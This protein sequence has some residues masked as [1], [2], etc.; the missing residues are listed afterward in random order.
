MAQTEIELTGS[1]SAGIRTKT[2]KILVSAFA[3]SPIRGSEFAVGWEWIR[4]IARNHSVWAITRESEREEIE[5]YLRAHPN[6]LTNVSFCFVP[7]HEPSYSG[8]LLHVAYRIEYVNW[9]KRCFAMARD[10]DVKVNFDIVH[11]VNGTGFREPGFLWKLKKPFVWGPILGL[12]YFQLKFLKLI[13]IGE[14]T[15][16]VVKNLTTAWMMHVARRPRQAASAA[17]RILAGTRQTAT[18]VDL[19]WKTP[20]TVI[21]PVTPP[22]IKQHPPARRDPGAPLR[23]IWCGSLEPRKALKLLLLSLGSLKCDEVKWELLVI[24]SGRMEDRCRRMACDLGI[25]EHC[26]FLGRLPRAE[27][28]ALIQSGHV[29]VHSSLY[30]GSPTTVVEAMS[31]GLPL[32]GMD[33]FGFGDAVD[34]RCGILI[35]PTDI[36]SV[37][38][39]FAEAIRK[40]WRDEELRYKMALAAQ[41]A[42]MYLSWEHKI[43]IVESIYQDARRLTYRTT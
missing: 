43:Q 37:I 22:E 10:L 27:A 13:P 23:L 9:Q 33:H 39:E 34:D 24:G 6:E 35:P 20:A 41:T 36:H 16:L 25:S 12:T 5:D 26:R 2:L 40:L 21:S 32:V 29:F 7:W 38:V 19:L 3:A 8:I 15:F 31:L 30:E 14:A 1:N 18:M 11:H 42:A 28:L 17:A 4:A